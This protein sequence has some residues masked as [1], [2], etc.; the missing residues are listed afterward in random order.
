MF[1]QY[2][3]GKEVGQWIWKDSLGKLEQTAFYKNGLYDSI[4]I[5]FYPDG[6]KR[7]ERVYKEGQILKS[8]KY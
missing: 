6:K 3:N 2:K 8:K 1:G 7:E 5:E 4:A